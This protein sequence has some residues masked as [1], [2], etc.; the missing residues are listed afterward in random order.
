MDANRQVDDDDILTPSLTA[1]DDAVGFDRPW[2]PNYLVLV[3]AF[4]GV[5]PMGILLA[6]NFK[7]LGRPQA[8]APLLTFAFVAGVALAALAGYA[9]AYGIPGLY[10]AGSV[11]HRRGLR[12]ANML[13][14]VGVGLAIAHRQR[15]RWEIHTG[16]GGGSAPLLKH[17]LGAIVAG[18]A[19]Q[20]MVALPFA[21]SASGGASPAGSPP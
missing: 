5:I 2:N 7:R 11:D 1:H 20:L 4:F 9:H 18:V 6:E 8:Y 10:V 14:A 19:V 3:G 21:I 12:T 13:L 15:R 17:A 16:H